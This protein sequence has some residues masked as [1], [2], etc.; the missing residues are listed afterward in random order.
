MER[1]RYVVVFD[2]GEVLATPTA[3]FRDLSARAGSSEDAIE[4][5]YWKY[6]LPHDEGGL[7]LDYWTQVLSELDTKTDE[8]VITDLLGID[9]A[10]WMSLRDDA[11]SLLRELHE[12]RVTVAIL[13]NMPAELAAVARG[14]SWAAWVDHWFFSGE[15]GVAKPDAAIYE[16]ASASL[17]VDPARIV[18]VDDRQVNVDAAVGAGWEAHLWTSGAATRDLIGRLGI[19]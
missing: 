12:A 5:A 1:S 9:T 11:E 15:M 4:A 17:G 8:A 19:I 7:A 13:S 18:F 14:T 2:L 10:A 3:L 16:R 6:R